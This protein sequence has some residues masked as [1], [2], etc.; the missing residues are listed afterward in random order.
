MVTKPTKKVNLIPWK[1]ASQPASKHWVLLLFFLNLTPPSLCI[2]V[3]LSLSLF[4]SLSIKLQFL[5]INLHSINTS[6]SSSRLMRIQGLR[7]EAFKA[8]LFWYHFTYLLPSLNKYERSRV[9]TTTELQMIKSKLM[10]VKHT[11]WMVD[12]AYLLVGCHT[13]S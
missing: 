8:F 6:Y 3:S 2:S 5:A 12:M 13:V 9:L 7:F 10:Q 1:P 11:S 4:L